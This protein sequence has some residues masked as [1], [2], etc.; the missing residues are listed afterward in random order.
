MF[1]QAENANSLKN[2]GNP[3]MHGTNAS[4]MQ[5]PAQVVIPVD[6]VVPDMPVSMDEDSAHLHAMGQKF[7]PGVNPAHYSH[8][9]VH[10]GSVGMNYQHA[11]HAYTAGLVAAEPVVDLSMPM[12]VQ[13]DYM[14]AP[15]AA[16]RQ[17]GD[18]FDTWYALFLPSLALNA[19]RKREKI[20]RVV[21]LRHA[22]PFK[23]M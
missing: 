7:H 1:V 14:G 21:N 18:I 12:N 11:A 17:G 6:C 9:M 22:P 13:P 20:I 16:P 19:G 5:L 4:C 8:A 10:N 3:G 23:E 15:F 2:G